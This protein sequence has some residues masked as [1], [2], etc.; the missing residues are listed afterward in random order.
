MPL[1]ICY[2]FIN[3]HSYGER[4][5]VREA[6]R[7]LIAHVTIH[8][9]IS[10]FLFHSNPRTL[11]FGPQRPMR[12]LALTTAIIFLIV[13][14]G[15]A[16]PRKNIPDTDLDLYRQSSAENYFIA[17]KGS[18]LFHK[19]GCRLLKATGYVMNPDDI[20]LFET[21]KDAV[22][23]NYNACP[24]CKPDFDEYRREKEE[25]E[26]L[27][28]IFSVLGLACLTDASVAASFSGGEGFSLGIFDE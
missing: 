8:F 9:Q 17:K 7:E 16:Y 2:N 11:Y 1:Q 21:K 18:I 10:S 13:T 15:C 28:F 6:I 4:I 27:V 3:I 12:A 23:A 25:S 5:Q 19:P 24:L 26:W 22:K 14:S 20:I